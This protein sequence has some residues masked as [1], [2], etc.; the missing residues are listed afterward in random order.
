V[1]KKLVSSKRLL[2]F[3]LL[4]FSSNPLFAIELNQVLKSTI[5]HYPKVQA[6][7]MEFQYRR[8][9]TIKAQGAF[10]SKLKVENK[11]WASG[12]YDA[13]ISKVAIERRLG[14]LGSSISVGYQRST[15]VL[16]I[17][18]D[19]FSTLSE[20]EYFINLQFELLRNRSIDQNRL[21]V[22]NTK[23]QQDIQ[24]LQF[25]LEQTEILR[26]ARIAYAKLMASALTMDTYQ[27]L[28]D[29]AQDRQRAISIK[30]KRGDL[31]RIYLT[32]NKQYIAKRKVDFIKAKQ[33]FQSLVQYF[34]LFYRDKDGLPIE[35]KKEEVIDYLNDFTGEKL[36]KSEFEIALKNSPHF[37]I[38]NLSLMV[39]EN[40]IQF[41]D[42]Q[43]LPK[44]TVKIGSSSNN[45]NGPK[46]LQEQENIV[47]LNLEIPIE[48]RKIES[49]L[50]ISKVKLKQIKFKQR[51]FQ[52]N[53]FNHFRTL[54]LRIHADQKM[55]DTIKNEVSYAIELERAERIKFDRGASDYFVLNLRE[56]N[57][58]DAQIKRI[59]TTLDLTIARA[60]YHELLFDDSYR[61]YLL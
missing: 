52:D 51:M 56:Q 59:Q 38:F 58:V 11:D 54:Q 2:L 27:K 17:Y 13:N 10:D 47:A 7:L 44:L 19:E 39:Q 30:V 3:L 48:R 25:Q 5:K 40:I 22:A 36:T 14:A 8:L 45:G 26:N 31:A 4:L 20:G 43:I 28:L 18:Q 6:S 1:N 15:G 42:N 12:Y 23:L 46:S 33:K 53:F 49:D 21:D 34:A 35:V 32:E 16:P 37:K 9:N 41:K 24:Q 60:F 57:T 50:A 29:L 55:L 61:K